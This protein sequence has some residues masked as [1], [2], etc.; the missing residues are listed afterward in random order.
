MADQYGKWK[1]VESLGE[2]GQGHTFRVVELLE[3]GTESKESYVLKR[4]KTLDQIRRFEDEIAA[5]QKLS[6]PNI[7][8][9][10]D[11]DIT[12]PKPYLVSEYCSGGSLNDIDVNSYTITDRLSMFSKICHAVGYAHSNKPRIIHRDLKPKNIFLREDRRSPVV[13]DF[14]IC[15]I[16][17][18][19]TRI[20]LFDEAVGARRYTAPELE[21]GRADDV[22]P[23]ADVYSLGKIL[24][25]LMAGHVFDREKH[26]E[27]RF[28]LTQDQKDPTMHW[29]YELLD[30][31]IVENPS[32]RFPDSKAVAEAVDD[33]I[34]KVSINARPLDLASPQ[35][36]L[37]CGVGFYKKRIET[38]LNDGQS[39]DQMV[40][41]G[42]RFV[43]N[44]QWLILICDHCGNSQIFVRNFPGK[45]N[46][47]T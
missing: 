29:I 6:H 33:I 32:K 44:Q 11:Q 1:V 20:T 40:N 28:D 18:D 36:C 19:G 37:Y 41:S 45:N 26:R 12:A 31:M 47:K 5:C 13:G 27:N 43:P 15:Y 23:A 9:V 30:K 8:R 34:K 46:W 42:F 4:L 24:Y 39:N 14:G 35:P 16:E 2:G 17:D 38:N 3:D 7:L 25:W 10:I 21:D 22:T